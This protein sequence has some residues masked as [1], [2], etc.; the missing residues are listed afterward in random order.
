MSEPL[1]SNLDPSALQAAVDGIKPNQVIASDNERAAI[2]G[3]DII[4]GIVVSKP[5]GSLEA[6]GM[7]YLE[8]NTSTSS[9]RATIQFHILNGQIVVDQVVLA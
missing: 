7:V 1:S 3:V 9:R 8:Q 6:P 2:V 5:D 4:P